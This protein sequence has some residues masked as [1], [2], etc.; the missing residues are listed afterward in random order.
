MTIKSQ[1][2]T[3]LKQLAAFKLGRREIDEMQTT[4]K[5]LVK[6]LV[7]A[8]NEEEAQK[9]IHSVWSD[10]DRATYWHIISVIET[11]RLKN[12]VRDIVVPVERRKFET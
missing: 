8:P 5:T 10:F 9:V 11:A 1:K 3:W 7:I 6:E 2:G 12:W 4:F